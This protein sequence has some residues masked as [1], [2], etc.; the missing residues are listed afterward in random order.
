MINI[1]KLQQAMAAIITDSAAIQ[2]LFEVAGEINEDT[3][4]VFK[5]MTPPSGLK[6]QQ[7]DNDTVEIYCGL[8][9]VN[10]ED[11][12]DGETEIAD[13]VLTYDTETNQ[14]TQ[15][16]CCGVSFKEDEWADR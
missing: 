12:F 6:I 16:A 5:L 15:A 1:T 4:G 2:A 10:Y 3:D 8:R 13:I 14:L 11:D 7:K 9:W